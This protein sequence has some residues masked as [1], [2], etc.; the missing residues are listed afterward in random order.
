MLLISKQKSQDD[1]KFSRRKCDSFDSLTAW[2]RKITSERSGWP[3]LVLLENWQ[4]RPETI[5]KSFP[6]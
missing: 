4:F 6:L 1:T 5:G 3:G 2:F